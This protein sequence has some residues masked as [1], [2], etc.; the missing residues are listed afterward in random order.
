MLCHLIAT[1]QA[2][3]L[4]LTLWT[5]LHAYSPLL[6][7]PFLPEMYS[8]GNPSMLRVSGCMLARV[9][10]DLINLPHHKYSRKWYRCHTDTIPVPTETL[11]THICV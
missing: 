4:C 11:K 9:W 6:P 3:A 8:A 5:A 7:L 2:D 1:D 10:N